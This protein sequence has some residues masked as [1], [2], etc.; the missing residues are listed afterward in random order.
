MRTS[1]VDHQVSE[2]DSSDSRYL[3]RVID[4]KEK[5]NDVD[6][7]VKA[8]DGETGKED[9]RS[10]RDH[11]QVRLVREAKKLTEMPADMEQ[12]KY[13]YEN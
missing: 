1:P 8:V 12:Y 2:V 13:F 4:G 10:M 5:I 7:E 6:R 11:A 3:Q 9:V